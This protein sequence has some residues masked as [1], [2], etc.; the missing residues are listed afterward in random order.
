[1]HARKNHD[2][3]TEL[4]SGQDADVFR[5][6]APAEAFLASGCWSWEMDSNHT[7]YSPGFVSVFN[8]EQK[9]S[10]SPGEALFFLERVEEPYRKTLEE[11]IRQALLDHNDF[12]LEFPIEHDVMLRSKFWVT[13]NASGKAV[14][15]NAVFQDITDY[16][17]LERETQVCL[18]ELKRS[19][20]E[21]EEFSYVASHDMQEPLR[22]ISMFSE[23]L[24]NK[25]K[26]VLDQEGSLY[27]DRILI[28]AENMR[29]LIDGLLDFSRASRSTFAFA[30]VP[31]KELIEEVMAEQG[32][33][34]HVPIRVEGNLPTVQ[35]VRHEMK[36]LFSNLLS[37][38]IKFTAKKEGDV[39]ITISASQITD[40]EREALKL[41]AATAYY[42][43]DVSDTGIGFEEE[44]T[45]KIFRIFQRLHGKAEYPGAGIGLAI[46]KK[47]VQ[48]HQG[49]ILARSRV[50]R[51]STFSVILPEK[52]F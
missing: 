16:K 46:C 1:M 51:G 52:Q 49:L 38:A 8:Y 32:A 44:Y 39:S 25:Y 10:T 34:T 45:D 14:R 6:Y 31:M 11:K 12:T 42:R 48:N 47:I 15:L 4:N 43:I 30:A 21:M 2:F 27:I 19:Q 33:D 13:A 17:K 35:A 5:D 29:K 9:P 28:S 26:D 7:R 50:N 24:V 18:R 37:N 41:S 20:Q 23:R 22:K 36:H 40:K 3:T